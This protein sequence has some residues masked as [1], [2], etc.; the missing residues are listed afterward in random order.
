MDG[1]VWSTF[2]HGDVSAHFWVSQLG[3]IEQYVDS[4]TVAWH[5]GNGEANSTYC[6]VETEG[7]SEPPYADVMS[8]AMVA[9]LGRLYAEGMRR[10]GWPAV[11]AN[12]VGEPGFG[13]H[14][15]ASAT[16]CP[17]DVR[18]NRRPEILDAATGGATVGPPA[19]RR[20]RQMFTSTDTGQG[21]WTATEDGAVYAFGDAEYRGSP[22]DDRDSAGSADRI[23]PG[24]SVLSIE[25]HGT[26]GYW[27]FITDG[28]VFAYGSAPFKGRPDRA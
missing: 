24:Q 21:Y 7:C 9:G 26:D 2:E 3:E 15:M 4:E 14:R 8:D 23:Q 20:G 27:L 1:S 13:Y 16:A 28:S 10:H 17:C 12:A 19:K 6:G 18:L 22:Y 5:A 25:G 11:L